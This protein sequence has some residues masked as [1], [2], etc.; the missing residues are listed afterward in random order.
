MKHSYRGL[1]CYQLADY[2]F[3]II[4]VL[5]G[6]TVYNISSFGILALWQVLSAML[7]YGVVDGLLIKWKTGKWLFPA[8]GIISAQIIALLINPGDL[9]ITAEVVLI[10]L[11]LKHI[12]KPA[13]RNIF[14]PAV[15]GIVVA[16][17]FLPVFSTWWG[18]N[19]MIVGIS[20]LLLL[21][22]I[23]RWQHAISF[24]VAYNVFHQAQH[25]LL[26]GAIHSHIDLLQGPIVFFALFMLIEPVTSPSTTRG[27]VIFGVC[28]ALL[29][30]FGS[31]TPWMMGNSF[32][33]YIPLLFMN[34]MMRVLPNKYLG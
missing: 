3:A 16:S 10:T 4:V 30:F 2:K 8:G 26:E 27:R 19:G 14:N 9:F 31:L 21:I 28:V 11:A 13:Y 5:L 33:L 24:L 18:A 34:L 15:L 25:L 6:L 20:G 32:F 12:V 7:L 29:V 22:Y 1:P 17:F 23:K